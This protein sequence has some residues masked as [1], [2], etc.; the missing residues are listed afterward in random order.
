MSSGSS[1][2]EFIPHAG[3][4][5]TTYNVLERRGRIRWLVREKPLGEADNGWRVFSHIDT[6]EYLADRNNWVMV[7]F[8]TLC[9]LEPVVIGVWNMP[10]GSDL[11]VVDDGGRIRLVDTPTGR[12]IPLEEQFDPTAPPPPGGWPQYHGYTDPADD[13]LRSFQGVFSAAYGE[14]P[15]PWREVVFVVFMLAPDDCRFRVLVDGVETSAWPVGATRS[16]L[17][18]AAGKWYA[19][20]YRSDFR[21]ALFGAVK[22]TMEPAEMFFKSYSDSPGT[23]AASDWGDIFFGGDAGVLRSELGRIFEKN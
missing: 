7:D 8:N 9:N 13:F 10:V 23:R 22:V 4:S 2:I 18:E 14:L 21:G 12:E 6:S 11:Q 17:V 20:A 3:A 16:R 5:M 1:D 15:G 19:G